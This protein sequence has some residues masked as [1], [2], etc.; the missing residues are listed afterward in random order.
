MSCRFCGVGVLLPYIAVLVVTFAF[1]ECKKSGEAG[2][3]DILVKPE[4]LTV[5][6]GSSSKIVAIPYPSVDEAVSFEWVSSA[7]AVATV[8]SAG[9]VVGKVPG[10]AIITVSSGAVSKDILVTVVKKVLRSMSV[11]PIALTLGTGE[12]AT[13]SVTLN[14]VDA[15]TS[16]SWSSDDESVAKVSAAGVVTGIADGLTNIAVSAGA[17]VQKIPVMVNALTPDGNNIKAI[18]SGPAP[19]SAFDMNPVTAY[20]SGGDY[21]WVGLD[22]GVKHVINKVA[23]YPRQNAAELMLLGLFE[24]ANNADFSDAIPLSIITD[25][26]ENGKLSSSPVSVT[27]GVRYVRYVGP[28]TYNGGGGKTPSNCAVAELAFFGAPGEGDDSQFVQIAG[29]PSVVIHVEKNA[30]VNSKENYLKGI[31]SF[32]Y[33]DGKTIYSDSVE[34]RGRGN[35]SW[36]MTQPNNLKKPYRIK[37][38]NS[39]KLMGNPAKGKSWTLINNWGDKTLM[40]NLLAFD[41]SRL[42]EMPYTPAG[43]AVNLFYNGEYKGCY[44]LCD[45]IDIRK[46][47]VDIKEMDKND[48][49]GEALTGGYLI[50]IDAY[51]SGEPANTWITTSRNTPITIKSPD[52]VYDGVYVA[53]QKRYIR[54]YFNQLEAALHGADYTDPTVGYR[55]Y[56]DTYSFIRHFLV[57]E[58]CGNT[59]TYWSVYMSKDRNSNLFVTGPVWDFD[60]AFDNDSRTYPISNKTD[61]LFRSGGSSIAGD[62]RNFVNR[63]LSDPAFMTEM[64]TAWKRYRDSGAISV[65]AMHACIDAHAAKMNESQ[66]LNFLRWK[67]I[68]TPVHLNPRTEGSYNGE[69]SRIKTYISARIPW[70]DQQLGY[71]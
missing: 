33:N 22:L 11:T 67:I 47:R 61:W 20:S 35:A 39:V 49:S 63:L 46:G 48:I 7:P 43:Q 56:L 18:G 57:G 50:E 69:V 31:A 17:I 68:S 36:T 65:G 6:V 5:E 8:S 62:M 55:K 28:T 71:K 4:T 21:Q 26:P 16:L 12:T 1:A 10:T 45:H 41:V 51:A 25:T 64:R 59:D 32:I 52:I 44:Q 34:I 42:V 23:Y 3:Q 30:E 53:E 19:L 29:I 24:G 40:R 2:L 38:Y 14:P 15:E 37:L 60:L 70:I 54:D 58:L 66:R 13:L 9:T 27:R